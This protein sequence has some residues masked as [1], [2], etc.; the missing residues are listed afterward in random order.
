ML[1]IKKELQDEIK[2]KF[3]FKEQE[4]LNTRQIFFW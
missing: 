1:G 3:C 2:P 4:S